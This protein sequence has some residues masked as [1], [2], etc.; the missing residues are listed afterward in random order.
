M[1]TALAAALIDFLSLYK[2]AYQ[3]HSEDT[4]ENASQWSSAPNTSDPQ[5]QGCCLPAYAAAKATGAGGP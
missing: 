1:N 3:M 2:T 5:L 4:S